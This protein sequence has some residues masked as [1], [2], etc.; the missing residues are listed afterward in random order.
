MDSTTREP[1]Q[2]EREHC[3]Q[4]GDS[5][6]CA[7]CEAAYGEPHEDTCERAYPETPPT[8]AEYEEARRRALRGW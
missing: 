5:L 6:V 4:Y 3:V 2:V 1:R 7:I 8:R